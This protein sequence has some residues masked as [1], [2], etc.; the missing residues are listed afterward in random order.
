MLIRLPVYIYIYNVFI[1]LFFSFFTVIP[2]CVQLHF[3]PHI[4][5]SLEPIPESF[6]F[7]FLALYFFSV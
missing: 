4:V 3:C 2:E 5:L 1:Y 6:Y 7:P